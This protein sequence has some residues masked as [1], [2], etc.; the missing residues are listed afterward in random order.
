VAG[1]G[2]FINIEEEE[3]L[4]KLNVISTLAVSTA[5][6]VGST[7]AG[8]I[9]QKNQHM[10]AASG[11]AIKLIPVDETFSH[12]ASGIQFDVPTGWKA[13]PDG[14]QMVISSP[15]DTFSVVFWVAEEDEF[16]AAVGALDEE[17]AKTI[18]K[19]KVTGEGKKGT[20]NGMPY[21]SESGTGEVEGVAVH[22]SVDLLKAK[23]PVI[24]LTFAASEFFNKH[25]NGY[26]KLVTSIKMAK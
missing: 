24:I 18:K 5:L 13:E 19:K 11:S 7:S 10:M 15:D 17:L 4:R 9:G 12:E 26:K 16:E 6:L 2:S 3:Y 20:H 14:E 22:W 21:Y 23:K 1:N 8:Q 25:I